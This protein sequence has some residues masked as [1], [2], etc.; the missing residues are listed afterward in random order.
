MPRKLKIDSIL[1][2][3]SAVNSL[4]EKAKMYNDAIGQSQFEDRK[5]LLEAEL[6]EIQKEDVTNAS[7]ALIFGGKPVCGSR[8]ISADFAGNIL[9]KYQEIISKLYAKQELGALL[10]TGRV[11]LKKNTELMVTEI[12]RGSFGFILDELS[13]QMEL[14]ETA[15]KTVVEE[16]SLIIEKAGDENAKEF[17]DFLEDIDSRTLKSLKE[18]F[19]E[20]DKNE[21]TIKIIEDEKEYSLNIEEIHR[22]KLRVESTDIEEEEE[23]VRGIILGVLPNHKKFEMRKQDGEVIWGTVSIEALEFYARNKT[24]VD[25]NWESTIIIKT[26]KPLNKP[27]RNVYRLTR[28][29]KQI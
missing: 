17:E 15:L 22:A 6:E 20:L 10:A 9:E 18:F 21:A 11:P 29:L 25:Q 3:L 2:D 23:V 7:V 16:A 13:D 1:A 26:I 5:N 19:T 27:P 4:I 8:G 14:T 12:A 24:I 28:F